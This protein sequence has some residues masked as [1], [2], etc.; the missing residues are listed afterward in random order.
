M[1][2]FIRLIPVFVLLSACGSAGGPGNGGLG[3]GGAGTVTGQALD[4]QGKPIAGAK[5]WVKPVVTTG[6]YETRTDAGGRYEA[7]GLPPVGYRV[8]A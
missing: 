1:K 5:I 6:L 7:I 4:A 3:N 8:L 2:N